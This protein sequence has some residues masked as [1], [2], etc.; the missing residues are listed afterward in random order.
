M[1]CY[2]E[3]RSMLESAVREAAERHAAEML[4]RQRTESLLAKAADEY[5][6][7]TLHGMIPEDMTESV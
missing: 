3:V 1:K 4:D 7:F 6:R 2:E 5:E